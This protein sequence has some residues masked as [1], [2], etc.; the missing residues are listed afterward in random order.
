MW[1]QI[2]QIKGRTQSEGVGGQGA[3]KIIWASKGGNDRRLNICIMR[4]LITC[5]PH[6]IL[7][8][9]QNKGEACRMHGRKEK[10]LHGLV[11]QPE[12]RRS[13]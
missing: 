10:S 1:K 5:T 13:L 8:G 6:I 7:L 11:R 4:S 12:G 3:E 9:L 2:S